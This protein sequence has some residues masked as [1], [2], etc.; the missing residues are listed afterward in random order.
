[1]ALG[2][3]LEAHDAPRRLPLCPILNPIKIHQVLEVFLQVIKIFE[4]VHVLRGSV[5]TVRP[6]E[7]RLTLREL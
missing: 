3:V 2:D 5:V 7:P 4:A 1:M 6:V